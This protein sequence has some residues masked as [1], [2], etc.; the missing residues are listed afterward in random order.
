MA[1]KPYFQYELVG[2]NNRILKD[3]DN[4][5]KASKFNLYYKDEIV[6]KNEP[7]PKRI[8]SANAKSNYIYK[9]K[10][11]I[12]AYIKQVEK[13]LARQLLEE[14]KKEKIQKEKPSAKE[15]IKPETK[16]EKI[17][18]V[19]PSVEIKE[20][21]TDREKK[22]KRKLSEEEIIQIE[23]EKLEAENEI[24]LFLSETSSDAIWFEDGE[25]RFDWKNISINQFLIL[26]NKFRFINDDDLSQ[27]YMRTI[28]NIDLSMIIFTEREKYK[29]TKGLG[30]SFSNITFQLDSFFPF[31]KDFMA[32]RE[33]YK[34]TSI[35]L[36]SIM[37]D[38]LKSAYSD[39]LASYNL[40]RKYEINV[41]LYFPFYVLHEDKISNLREL[42][43]GYRNEYE[44]AMSLDYLEDKSM[45]ERNLNARVEEFL[46]K[47]PLVANKDN[48]SS[49]DSFGIN[50]YYFSGLNFHIRHY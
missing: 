24:D 27:Y 15:P 45:F 42:T 11:N 23:M 16:K 49:F 36:A 48:Y 22:E 37:T 8:K 14:S 39:L 2:K 43:D 3:G 20:L 4:F 10:E 38:I 26:I 19:I 32:Y 5:D 46:R 7:F 50:G 9:S 17:K 1:R 18:E 13:E 47:I 34:K 21:P 29:T 44:N 35:L 30:E 25:A 28:N 41:S 12:K 6:L 33:R 31:K 40:G